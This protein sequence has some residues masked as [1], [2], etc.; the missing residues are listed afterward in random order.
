M[1]EEDQYSS[2]NI[3]LNFLSIALKQ[4]NAGHRISRTLVLVFSIIIK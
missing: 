4:P 1:I 2:Q 3:Q